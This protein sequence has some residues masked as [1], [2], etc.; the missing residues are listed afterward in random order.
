MIICD[1]WSEQILMVAFFVVSAEMMPD[2]VRA[3][4]RE[5]ATHTFY[6]FCVAFCEFYHI[7]H[8]H[9]Y[10]YIITH[11]DD[12]WILLIFFLILIKILIF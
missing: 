8:I 10:I 11:H 2:V 3:K 1:L 6:L 5:K 7:N 4:R 9:T 12:R